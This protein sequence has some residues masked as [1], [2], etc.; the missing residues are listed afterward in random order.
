MPGQFEGLRREAAWRTDLT[1]QADYLRS[2]GSKVEVITPDVAS[3][4]AMGTNAMDFAA[5]IPSARAGYEQG[6]REAA[7]LTFV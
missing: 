6:K 3:R 7:R 1:S 4:A 5:R 2:R